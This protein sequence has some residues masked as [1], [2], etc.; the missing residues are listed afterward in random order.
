MTSRVT[1]ICSG[2]LCLLL[3]FQPCQPLHIFDSVI[4][5]RRMELV[6][7]KASQWD[8]FLQRLN[9][10]LDNDT[11]VNPRC[12]AHM[13]LF[14]NAMI[15]RENAGLQLLDAQGSFPAGF[16]RGS[17]AEM[18]SYKQCF[19]AAF[20]DET[21]APLGRKFCSTMVYPND[22]V[23]EFPQ[24]SPEKQRAA[25]VFAFQQSMV[26]IGACYPSACSNEE[27]M[28]ILSR[29]FAERNLSSFISICDR[30][31]EPP[32]ETP[33]VVI[34]VLGTFVA[35]VAAATILDLMG[36]ANLPLVDQ[37]PPQSGRG[38]MLARFQTLSLFASFRSTFRLDS[39]EGGRL[40]IFNGLRVFALV[41]VVAIHTYIFM[42]DAFIADID[43]VFEMSQNVSRQFI[44]NATMSVAIF[45]TVSGFMQWMAVSRRPIDEYGKASWFAMVLHRYL[46]LFPLV[47]VTA[48]FHQMA[49]VWGK[50]PYWAVYGKLRRKGFPN[51][52]PHYIFGTLNLIDLSH[53]C[54]P[55][56]WYTAADFQVF[57]FMLVFTRR[58][59]RTGSIKPLLVIIGL[60][61]LITYVQNMELQLGPGLIYYTPL[62]RST[63]S[64]FVYYMPY[65]H[66]TSYA[67]G[68]MA[69][70]YYTKPVARKIS[71]RKTTLL[72]AAAVASIAFSLFGTIL[73]TGPELPSQVATAAFAAVTRVLYCGGIAW[74]IYACLTGRAGFLANILAWPGWAPISRLSFSI[75]IIHD[76][77]LYE[78]WIHFPGRV[79]GGNGFMMTL[80]A[81]NCV[82][83]FFV[84]FALHALF[85]RPLVLMATILEE[86]ILPAPRL[87]S[88]AENEAAIA[89]K[90]AARVRG[91]RTK[92]L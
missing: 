89:K 55:Q 37:G 81:G 49:P 74:V 17:L 9:A 34:C 65:T 66:A 16:L 33:V 88:D 44:V 14:I 42:E 30:N 58:L 32:D 76:F 12:L 28:A 67:I 84:A 83:S 70:Y 80:V 52:W 15:L 19:A 63:E 87:P 41:W 90:M 53:I 26:N 38:S 8:P 92:R 29:V 69:G 31:D 5:A 50:G 18:G 6:K 21:G 20:E 72:W 54:S 75:Y 57:A 3:N 2:L 11:S 68:I 1:W 56:H 61:M 27:I 24:V 64:G 82:A 51:N 39:G 78:Q 43:D 25:R 46:R 13:R 35:A 62:G 10:S 71:K 91:D 47:A 77:V 40:D 59:K 79:S 73:W 86:R 60:A 48:C 85:E 36:R 7:Y 22:V 4:K 45:M 23:P